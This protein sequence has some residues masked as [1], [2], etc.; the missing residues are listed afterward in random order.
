[1]ENERKFIFS[2]SVYVTKLIITLNWIGVS[3]QTQNFTE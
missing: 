1:M 3:K 2:M